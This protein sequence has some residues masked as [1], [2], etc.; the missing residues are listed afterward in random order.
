[1]WSGYGQWSAVNVGGHAAD[2]MP[3]KVHRDSESPH[4]TSP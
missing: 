4:A 3:N 1:M 2:R